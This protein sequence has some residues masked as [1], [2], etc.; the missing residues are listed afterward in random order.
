MFIHLDIQ[1]SV[2]IELTESSY[3]KFK[4]D[5]QSIGFKI[6]I[7]KTIF[8]CEFSLFKEFHFI[9]FDI[10]SLNNDERK[11]FIDQ[12]KIIYLIVKVIT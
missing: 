1:Q 6:D 12:P 11:F 2:D 3:S 7:I 8:E 9:Y 4:R 5:I 10:L